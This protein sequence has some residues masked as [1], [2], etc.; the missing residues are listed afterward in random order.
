MKKVYIAARF[1]DR[2]LV[3][4][5]Y[6]KLE[7]IGF[8]IAGDWTENVSR[9]PYDQYPENTTTNVIKDVQGVQSCDIF[10]M[11]THA[12]VG[13]GSSAE[14]GCA[15]MSYLLRNKPEI[16]VVGEH[17]GNNFFYFHPCVKR[18]KKIEEVFAEIK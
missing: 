11:L 1:S 7:K 14:L 12:E 10:I 6:V 2:L 3:K 16:Y 8:R 15:V 4:K 13:S 18:R 17:M 9:K 5:L